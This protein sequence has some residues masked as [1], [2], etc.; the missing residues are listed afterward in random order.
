MAWYCKVCTLRYDVQQYGKAQ[1]RTTYQ[2]YTLIGATAP[3]TIIVDTQPTSSNTLPKFS[4][5]RANDVEKRPTSLENRLILSRGSLF[6]REKRKRRQHRRRA[7]KCRQKVTPPVTTIFGSDCY[8]CPYIREGERA[9]KDTRHHHHAV[10]AN[11]A[12]V[13]FNCTSGTTTKPVSGILVFE[14]PW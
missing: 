6:C 3:T 4:K 10:R 14:I 9:R 7:I 13:S 5:N 12:Y 11:M 1:Y 8:A 2:L